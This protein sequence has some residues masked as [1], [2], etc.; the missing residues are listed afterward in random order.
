MGQWAESSLEYLEKRATETSRFSCKAPN[1]SNRPRKKNTMKD[2]LQGSMIALHGPPKVG[3]TQFCSK[4][5]GPVQWLATEFG[6]RYIPEDQR[7]KLVQMEPDTG[8]ELLRDWVRSKPRG[9]KTLVI[10]TASGFYTAC[11]Q[12]V[13]AKN[14]WDHPSDG[15]H[16]KGWNAVRAEMYDML[17]RLTSIAN[18]SKATLII[19]DHSKEEVIETSTEK[20]DKVTF[21]MSGQAKSI[22]LPIPDHMWFLGYGDPDPSSALK[23]DIVSPRTLFI[24]GSNRIEA[25]CRDP[26]VSSKLLSIKKLSKVNPY[27][28]IVTK[29][30]GGNV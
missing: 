29:L 3:K 17:S 11:L 14:R 7:K 25:G 4:F 8:W 23:N 12:W 24:G 22:V 30:Y 9:F 13:C 21:A 19:I 26:K 5:P 1:R 10:D 2:R 6:H 20:Y 27:K 18:R 15:D 28:Q 16:G